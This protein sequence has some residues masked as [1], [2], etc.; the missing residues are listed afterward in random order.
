MGAEQQED[1]ELVAQRMGELLR[2]SEYSDF[3]NQYNALSVRFSEL[4]SDAKL[5]LYYQFIYGDCYNLPSEVQQF[6]GLLY[7]RKMV[8]I[9]TFLDSPDYL[10]VIGKTVY[11][12]WRE[13]MRSFLAE[14]SSKREWVF[15]GSIGTGKS[16]ANTTLVKTS[17]G[18]RE[19]G[20]IQLGDLVDD[21]FGNYAT[22][23]G[24]YP[25]G[26]LEACKVTFA[27]GRTTLCCAEHLWLTIDGTVKN[28]STIAQE[29]SQGELVSIPLYTPHET[30]SEALLNALLDRCCTVERGDNTII[31][32]TVDERLA[33][34]IQQA[35]WAMGKVC[36]SDCIGAAEGAVQALHRVSISSARL[37]GVVSVEKL[38]TELHMTCI[39]V[40]SPTHTYVIADYII[41]HNTTI[42]R[43]VSLYKLY[44][45]LCLRYPH[46]TFGLTPEAPIVMTFIG[47]SQKKSRET[48]LKP[49][50]SLLRMCGEFEELDDQNKLLTY[51]GGKIPFCYSIADNMVRFSKNVF[52]TVSS[53]VDDLIGNNVFASFFDEAESAGNSPKQALELYAELKNR[54]KSRFGISRYN[55]ASIISSAR[56]QNGVIQTY[57]NSIPQDDK[58]KFV[59]ISEYT[60]WDVVTPIGI[61]PYAEGYFYVLN[62]NANYP[63]Q[64]LTMEEG[65]LWSKQTS[66][67]PSGTT[68]LKIPSMYLS[69]FRQNLVKSLQDVAGVPTSVNA[70]LFSDVSRIEDNRLTP[71]LRIS[72]PTTVQGITQKKNA[73]DLLQYLPAMCTVQ[74]KNPEGKRE[75][76]FYRY[77]SVARY[78]HIDLAEVGEAAACIIHKELDV[79]TGLTVYVVDFLV[80]FFSPTRIR[81]DSIY[82][83]LWEV[84]KK[85]GFFYHT[86]SFDQYQ[87]T[88]YRQRAAEDFLAQNSNLLSLDKIPDAYRY[89]ANVVSQDCFH[90][91]HCSKANDL[92]D[93]LKALSEDETGKIIKPH[94]TEKNHLDAVDAAVGAVWNAYQNRLDVPHVLYTHAEMAEQASKDA[95]VAKAMERLK[96]G[97]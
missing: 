90:V 70:T 91:G 10:G 85:Y 83:F 11:P 88:V 66:L 71:T 94:L 87:S 76:M 8:D 63:S 50:V 93:Q 33:K 59:Q 12:K 55:F 4:P 1:I 82:E 19:M 27:D 45:M 13:E 48:A 3:C 18:W 22:V 26:E 43:L 64:I 61:D 35:A 34:D 69:D 73:E 80:T 47:I 17:T 36:A 24:V 21:G 49:F 68:V 20:S 23:T 79:E 52:I 40:E 86:I 38:D 62:G 6:T 41:T 46:G 77:A 30:H 32:T 25:Q 39:S 75:A 97:W 9:D 67:V 74:K 92:L 16:V 7:D 96:L 81:L 84:K 14:D 78:A 72:V 15:S 2:S 44:Q 58:I 54:I 29:L 56:T 28:T 53:T 95:L 37:L 42:S 89:L 57:L 51:K 60:R 5:A 65:E 31:C